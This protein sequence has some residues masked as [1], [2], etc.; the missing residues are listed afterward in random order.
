M[1]KKYNLFYT[2]NKS[3]L[4]EK[5]KLYLETG[6]KKRN[7]VENEKSNEVKCESVEDKGEKK[8]VLEK[9]YKYTYEEL[10][11]IC[12]KYGIKQTG[13]SIELCKKI[14]DYMEKGEKESFRRKDVYK[15]DNKGKLIK[16]WQTV[17]EAVKEC[18][19]NKNIIANA[20]DQKY[21]V[22]E[23]IWRSRSVKFTPQ[24]LEEISAKNKKSKKQLTSKD[25]EVI[26]R[27]FRSGEEKNKLMSEYSI[28]MTQIRRILV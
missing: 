13:R 4:V 12:Q 20:L 27:R 23:F 26:R 1:C 16:H 9:L 7:V 18:D 22:N 14:R 5:L 8:E 17:T 19:L 28:S 25:H 10:V 11:K 6:E 21:S 15:Y 3:E 24:E 2:G